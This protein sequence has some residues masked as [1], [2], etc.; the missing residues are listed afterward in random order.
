MPLKHAQIAL[1]LSQ[2]DEMAIINR[3]SFYVC[4]S[5]GYAE[6]GKPTKLSFMM[7]EHKRPA[8]SKCNCKTLKR[9]SLGYRFGT[10]VIQIRFL[11]PD[12]SVANWAAAYSVMVGI[13]RGLC[14]YLSID[15]RDVSGCLQYFYNDILQHGSYAIILYDRTPGGSGYV[16]MLQN[17]NV[18]RNV[19]D[20]T[21]R[22]VNQCTCG[23]DE[24]DTSCYSCLRNYYNQSH[25]DDLKRSSVLAFINSI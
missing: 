13:L 24:K 23:G 25:H 20:E 2:K 8:G 21:Y 9:Y 12:L 19:L 7:K 16:R 3:S 17:P 6:L 1:R 10:D 22:I 18:F 11:S 5:C 15:E 4:E 14:S